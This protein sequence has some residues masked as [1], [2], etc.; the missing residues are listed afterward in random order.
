ME[1]YLLSGDW[2]STIF[3][4]RLIEMP[5]QHIIGEVFSD[6]G[7][8]HTFNSWKAGAADKGITR[9]Q[10]FID[11]LKKQKKSLSDQLSQSLDGITILI[12]GMAS[13]SIGMQELPYAQL[14][15]AVDGGGVRIHRFEAEDNFPNPILLISGVKSYEEVMRGE[16]TQLIG[17]ASLLNI[18]QQECILI[19]PGTHSKH[20]QIKSGKLISIK[21]FMTGELFSLL[22]NHSILK[23]SVDNSKVTELSE[24]EI[25]A[26]KSGLKRSADANILNSL[27][28][29]RTNQLF[30]KLDKK[31]NFYYLSGLLIGTELN[32]LCQMETIP[33]VLC[34]GGNLH[35]LYKLALHELGLLDKTTIVSADMI[36]KA[37]IA[38]Q[39][40]IYKQSKQ[41]HIL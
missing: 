41:T 27:F 28:T 7:V 3:R 4:L 6:N 9:K 1:K 20:L 2:G 10:F 40:I 21:T 12:S 11:Q 34:S 36:V 33:L 22:I 13:S 37:T 14:P 39:A 29:V 16:E 5:G 8:I 32:Y 30:N 18:Q 35:E 19:L 25:D 15:F 38:G 23:D 24:S 17:L 26:F 31:Q